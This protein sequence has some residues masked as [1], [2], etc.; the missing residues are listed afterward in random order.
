MIT[1]T[2]TAAVPSIRR[3]RVMAGETMVTPRARLVLTEN[4]KTE[5]LIPDCDRFYRNHPVVRANPELFEPADPKDVETFRHHR[6]LAERKL[7][8]LGGTTRANTRPPQQ[9]SL[10][11]AQVP[12]WRLP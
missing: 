4:G 2:A 5:E 6:Q 12:R 10:G 3:R 1:G 11:P 9:F 7:R 8:Q